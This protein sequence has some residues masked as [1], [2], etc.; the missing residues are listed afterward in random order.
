MKHFELKLEEDIE[1]RDKEPIYSLH[2]EDKKFDF[3]KR[4][5]FEQVRTKLS[6][7]SKMRQKVKLL[8][9]HNVS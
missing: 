6:E 8:F 4:V 7:L 5:D 1:Q 9:L 2:K 3:T